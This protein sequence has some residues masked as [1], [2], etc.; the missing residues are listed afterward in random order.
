MEV[1]VTA[2]PIPISTLIVVVWQAGVDVRCRGTSTSIETICRQKIE[3]GLI[4]Q[5]FQSNPNSIHSNCLNI[6]A[7]NSGSGSANFN[8]NFNFNINININDTEV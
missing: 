5:T 7:H 8:F 4:W 6:N 3:T 1:R 2:I